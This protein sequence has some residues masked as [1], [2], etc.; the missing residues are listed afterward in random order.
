MAQRIGIVGGTFDPIHIGHLILAVQAREQ[1]SLDR[2]LLIPNN[3]SPLKSNAPV[4]SFADR[5]AMVECA[6]AGVDGIEASDIE[7]QRGGVSYM[8]DTL[9]GLDQTYPGASFVLI[10]G[11]D[12]LHD[13]PMWRESDAIRRHATIA[14]VARGGESIDTTDRTLEVVSM[15]RVDISATEIRQRLN[16]GKS[17]DFLTPMSVITYIRDKGLY[18]Y[19][20]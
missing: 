1:L 7:G 6:V 4:A 19:R 17:I 16:A 3:Q 11:T 13:L 18:G 20:A 5:L 14:A 12:A 10:L 2:V 8:I 9:R 15:P